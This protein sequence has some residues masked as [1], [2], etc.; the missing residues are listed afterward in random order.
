MNRR[1]G[2]FG[3]VLVALVLSLAGGAAMAG[4]TW[5][6]GG[7]LAFKVLV[8]ALAGAYLVHLLSAS[9]EKVGRVVVAVAWLVVSCLIWVWAPTTA[10][11]VVTHVALIWLV[12]SLYFHSSLLGALADL[13][14]IALGLGAAIWAVG[15]SGSVFL[16]IWCFF[17]VQ[18]LFVAIGTI[19][20]TRQRVMPDVNGF[21]RA[22]S[23][24]EKAIRALAIQ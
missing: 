19:N 21:Q 4:G 24:A 9:D 11:Y 16:A 2:F 3:G 6:V 23:V 1:P 12:R 22:H 5:L 17:L 7:A 10:V 13:G 20:P 18:A 15:Q 8:P 14:L